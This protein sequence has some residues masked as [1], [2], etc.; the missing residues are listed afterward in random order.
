MNKILAYEVAREL[1]MSP[2]KVYEIC[3]SFH[4]GLR[5]TLMHPDKCKGGIMITN[6]FSLNL[7]N[8][9]VDRVINKNE[10]PSSTLL[11]VKE[12]LIKYERKNKPKAKEKSNHA[13]LYQRKS[14]GESN[15][16]TNENSSE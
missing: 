12:N 3:K 10:N 11:Q 15:G 5:Y 6:F 14:S 9:K 7:K 8:L 16:E 4:D 2:E 1:N 13:G